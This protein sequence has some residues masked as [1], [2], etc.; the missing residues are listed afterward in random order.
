VDDAW[1]RLKDSVFKA[2]ETLPSKALSAKKPWIRDSTLELI[3][4]RDDARH[5]GD[6]VLEKSLHW[7]IRKAAETDRAIWLDDAVKEGSW[8][9][10][11][12]LSKPRRAMQWR[13]ET[14]R[15]S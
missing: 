4:Q 12:K 5:A 11:H 14:I 1:S 6:H 3:G 8:K 2:G 9:G 15:E 10:V 13:L 7:S